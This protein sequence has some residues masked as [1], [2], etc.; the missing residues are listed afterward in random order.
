MTVS[1]PDVLEKKALCRQIM[2]A[3]L[4]KDRDLAMNLLVHMEPDEAMVY[5][6][7]MADLAAFSFRTALGLSEFAFKEDAEDV[8]QE[9][10]MEV[11][12]IAMAMVEERGGE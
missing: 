2:S 6:L 3:I 11:W 4:V 7:Y 12:Q 1:P 10:V 9:F 5:V 8:S